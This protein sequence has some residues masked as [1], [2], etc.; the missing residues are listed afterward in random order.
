MRTSLVPITKWLFSQ[1]GFDVVRQVKGYPIDFSK[2]E[3]KICEAVRPFTMTSPERIKA[4]INAIEYVVLNNIEGAL[5]ECGVWK[6]GSSMAMALTLK[7][8]G[9]EDRDIYMYDTYSGMSAPTD[10]DVS[11]HGTHAREELSRTRKTT[12]SSVWCMS[13]L[14]SVQQNVFSTNYRKER[15]HFIEGK[16][17]STIPKSMPKAISLLRLDTDWYESTKHELIHLFP[18]LKPNGVL[19]VDDYGHWEGARKAV[20]E[21]VKE[22][23][24]CILL[25]RVDYTGR[26]GIKTL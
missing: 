19:I 23:S 9:E 25:N 14:K 5:V 12:E 16:V 13:P 3:I 11:I 6:G 7:Q 20:D 18:L 26:I 24:I 15:I 21:Y 8:M 17:E 1:M 22:N 10:A 4:L 2:Q